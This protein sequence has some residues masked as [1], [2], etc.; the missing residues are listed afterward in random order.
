M[1][2]KEKMIFWPLMVILVLVMG[3]GFYAHSKK[4]NSLTEFL[5]D[6]EQVTQKAKAKKKIASF[7]VDMD[8]AVRSPSTIDDYGPLLKRNIFFRADSGDR[9]KKI[10]GVIELPEEEAPK[11]AIL[12]YKGRIML[13]AKVM[14]IIED[15]ATGKSFSVKE[16]DNVG[17]FTVTLIGEKE[18]TLKKKDGEELV[19]TTI[20]KEEK[21]EEATPEKTKGTP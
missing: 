6:I 5:D 15:Q 3:V 21:K 19:L 1:M 20:K 13:G 11:K 12:S 8:S 17:E 16:G 4:K 10:E 7:S 18:V 14:V 2:L 9:P